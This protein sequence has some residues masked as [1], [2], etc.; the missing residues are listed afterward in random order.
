MFHSSALDLKRDFQSQTISLKL[1]L[2]LPK[3][4]KM[5]EF[6][7]ALIML[8]GVQLSPLGKLSGFESDEFNWCYLEMTGMISDL[9]EVGLYLQALP[10]KIKVTE[11]KFD[12]T[13]FSS[14]N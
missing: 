8:T 9:I 11:I 12:S 6:L 7:L 2:K 13:I 3:R 14:N 10:V 4:Y 1:I 5:S